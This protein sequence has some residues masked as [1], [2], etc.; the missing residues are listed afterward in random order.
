MSEAVTLANGILRTL[1]ALNA[2]FFVLYI[3]HQPTL[4]P[5]LSQILFVCLAFGCWNFF[6]GLFYLSP[7][8][9]AWPVLNSLALVATSFSVYAFYEHFFLFRKQ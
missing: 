5:I 8:E 6:L 2:L 1:C 7:N 9:T 4:V 3:L